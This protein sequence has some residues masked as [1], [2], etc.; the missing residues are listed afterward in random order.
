[1]S[2]PCWQDQSWYNSIDTTA[3]KDNYLYGK[4][5]WCKDNQTPEIND[6]GNW[7]ELLDCWFDNSN[8]ETGG[9]NRYQW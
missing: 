8:D 6:V 2:F 4:L 1:M 9:V 3:I 5:S 7:F